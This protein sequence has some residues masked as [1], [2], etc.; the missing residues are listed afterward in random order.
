ME[1]C[2]WCPQEATALLP[3]SNASQNLIRS[4]QECV[5]QIEIS[6]GQSRPD[7]GAGDPFAFH[8]HI[9]KDVHLKAQLRSQI[10]QQRRRT[11]GSCYLPHPCF[12]IICRLVVVACVLYL[13]VRAGTHRSSAASTD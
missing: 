10:L 12:S 6:L 9:L 3:G 7:A 2:G 11:R 13:W 4:A 8:L 1:V 5:G